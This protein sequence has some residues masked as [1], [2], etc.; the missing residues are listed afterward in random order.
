MNIEIRS[1]THNADGNAD[2]KA[3][4][5]ILFEESLLQFYADLILIASLFLGGEAGVEGQSLRN[6]DERVA[7]MSGT[8]NKENRALQRNSEEDCHPVKATTTEYS[9][10]RPE[11]PDPPTRRPAALRTH[12]HTQPQTRC[13][14]CA[15]ADP[16]RNLRHASPPLFSACPAPR[17]RQLLSGCMP[18]RHG[19]HRR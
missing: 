1:Q 10:T 18:P 11:D 3:S 17:R 15:P 13:C 19:R 6:Y 9:R 14:E 4:E 12:P 8:K 16:K 5:Q 7:A 2:I